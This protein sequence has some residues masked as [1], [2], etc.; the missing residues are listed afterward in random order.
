MPAVRAELQPVGKSG[1]LMWMRISSVVMSGV[2]HLRADGVDDL[3]EIVRRD[4]GG[5]ADGDAGAAVDEQVRERRRENGR[6]RGRLVVVGDEVDRVLLHVLHQRGAEVRQ[7]RLGVTHGGGR[8]ALD[9]AEVALAVDETFA[10]DPGLGH[11]DER[12]VDHG[13]AVGMVIARGVAADLGAFAVLPAGEKRQVVHRVEDAPLGGLEAVARVGQRAGDDDGH[14]VIQEGLRHFLGHV[15]GLDFLVGIGHGESG[16]GRHSRADDKTTSSSGA[17]QRKTLGIASASCHPCSAAL[18]LLPE[19]GTLSL[20]RLIRP[21][22]RFTVEEYYRMGEAGILAPDA[23]VELLD[24]QIVEMFP[25]GPFHSGVGTRS[26]HLFDSSLANAGLFA[27]IP[28]PFERRLRTAARSCSGQT[29]ED[30]YSE[31]TQR[32]GRFPAGGSSG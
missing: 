24:G 1:P 31:R 3:A 23:R 22:H 2:V 13:L 27:P 25:I 29:R 15:D 5:H 14:R 11:V 17:G 28:G 4:V 7:A 6:L 12:R 26:A 32:R 30:F 9:A 19:S 10:H 21:H 20:M 16:G 18:I 8:I